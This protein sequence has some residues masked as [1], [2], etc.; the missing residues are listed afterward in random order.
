MNEYVAPGDRQ[1]G[2]AAELAARISATPARI[3]AGRA[4]AETRLA[5]HSPAVARRDAEPVQIHAEAGLFFQSSLAGSWVPEYLASR[6]LAAAL[7][8]TS[9]WKI[10]YAPAQWTAL[11][12]H[13]RRLG[14]C[15]A[16]L[17]CSGLITTGK[18]G[19]LRDRFHD[20]LMI[21]LRAQ[22]R[23]V[24]AFIGRRCPD[25]G[26]DHGPK[27]L[28]S[29]DTGMF[30]KGRVLAGLAEGRRAIRAGAQ[31][32]L[33]EGPLDAIAVSIAAPGQFTGVTPC[34]TALTGEQAALLALAVDLRDRGLRVALDADAAGRKAAVRV[35]GHLAHL[36]S[37]LSTVTL[38]DGRDPAEMLQRDGPLA[39]HAALTSSTRPLADLVV[40]ARIEEWSHGQELAFAEQQMGALRAAAKVIATMP[41]DQVGPQ[42]FRL[43]ALYTARYGWHAEEVNREIIDAIERHYQPSPRRSTLPPP[44]D[45][46]ATSATAPPRQR[47]V[48][49]PPELLRQHQVRVAHQQSSERD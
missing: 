25:A 20:R 13:L 32:V 33:V 19:R 12:D 22:D 45:A 40:D 14:H 24:I 42:A 31:P 43:S 36:T 47:T 6:G 48:S 10:G 49:C 16:A 2:P 29:P 3:A 34:G 11:T 27:Y 23:V 41:A 30:T 46:V 4:R 8:P 35:Y 39:L 26:D 15:D 28:N 21:P 44:I 9:P 37:D 1:T 5:L 7:L 18:D 38:P 17:L